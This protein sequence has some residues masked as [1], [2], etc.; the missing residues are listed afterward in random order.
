MKFLGSIDD[1]LTM[2]QAP[3]PRIRSIKLWSSRF[4][5]ILTFVLFAL[6]LA[7]LASL[8]ASNV[9]GFEIYAGTHRPVAFGDL[10]LP[11]AFGLSCLVFAYVLAFLIPLY[12][13]RKV[14]SEWASGKFMTV[15]AAKAVQATGIGIAAIAAVSEVL[16]VAMEYLLSVALPGYDPEFTLAINISAYVAAA[17]IFVSGLVLEEAAELAAEAELTI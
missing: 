10:D 8:V 17:A 2:T 7:V 11:F 5:G 12:F 14:F 1:D 16:S 3:S 15:T 6:P 9:W 13:L 4:C